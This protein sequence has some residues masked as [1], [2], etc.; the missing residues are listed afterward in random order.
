MASRQF[1]SSFNIFALGPGRARIGTTVP[2][3]PSN[4]CLPRLSA[5]TST[6]NRLKVSGFARYVNGSARAARGFQG[7]PQLQATI[8]SANRNSRI[9]INSP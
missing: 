3:Q 5:L 7:F 2:A 9:V 8:T 6:C 1:P 4:E